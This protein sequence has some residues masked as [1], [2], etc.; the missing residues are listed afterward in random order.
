MGTPPL[1][2][3]QD[4][5]GQ[6]VNPLATFPEY[7]VLGH[8]AAGVSFAIQHSGRRDLYDKVWLA[9]AFPTPLRYASSRSMI[10]NAVGGLPLLAGIVRSL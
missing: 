6:S 1:E 4:G 2:A 9:S 8:A 10:S 5:R 7:P 3:A